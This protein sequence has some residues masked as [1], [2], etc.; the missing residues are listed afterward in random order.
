MAAAR[1]GSRSSERCHMDIGGPPPASRGCAR[2]GIIA[3]LVLDGPMTGAA[4]RAYV[5]QALA[6]KSVGSGFPSISAMG[7][8]ILRPLTLGSSDHG[9]HGFPEVSPRIDRLSLIETNRFIGR[10]N[11]GVGG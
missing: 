11:H 2:A 9:L 8:S 10:I 4:F 3:P 5:E 7:S 1:A 6:P